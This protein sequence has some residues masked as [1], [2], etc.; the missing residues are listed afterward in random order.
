MIRDEWEGSQ[1]SFTDWLDGKPQPR[2]VHDYDDE[3]FEYFTCD[4]I[5]DQTDGGTGNIIPTLT[6]RDHE[7][8]AKL[9][10]RDVRVRAAVGVTLND[11]GAGSIVT[12]YETWDKVFRTDPTD[13]TVVISAA[14]AAG[15]G[16]T[17]RF[18]FTRASKDGPTAGSF[19]QLFFTG[20]Y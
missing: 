9:V 18:E 6:I 4:L 10:S 12:T 15:S 14:G 8:N 1:G 2:S 19:R 7:G 16:L 17:A 3:Q 11:G 20:V 13:G 5:G